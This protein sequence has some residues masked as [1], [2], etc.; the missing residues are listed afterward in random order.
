MSET[1]ARPCATCGNPFPLGIRA[2]T[3][4]FCSDS[5][6]SRAKE[7]RQAGRPEADADQPVGD[8]LVCR[9]TLAG[10]VHGARYCSDSCQRRGRYREAHGLPLADVVRDGC[11]RCGKPVARPNDSRSRWCSLTCCDRAHQYARYHAARPV[12]VRDCP[13]CGACIPPE[14]PTDKIFCTQR[15]ALAKRNPEMMRRAAHKRRAL[16]KA[17]AHLVVSLR[18]ARRLQRGPCA[19]CGG[20]AGTVDHVLPLNRGGRHSEGNLVPACRSCNSSKGD[21]LLIE[22]KAWKSARSTYMAAAAS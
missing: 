10:K 17:V 18:F 1:T 9:G 4:R 16:L 13:N 14:A 11:E 5:C 3:K 12:L 20:R 21:K 2:K 22:W 15:C 7:R 19:Y 8:C 6:R